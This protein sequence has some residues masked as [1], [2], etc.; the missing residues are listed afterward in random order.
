MN[1]I[2]LTFAL[3]ISLLLIQSTAFAQD[4]KAGDLVGTWLS[5]DGNGHIHIYEASGKYF[6]KS[7]SATDPESD[8]TKMDTNNADEKRKNTLLV[9]VFI[10]KDFEYDEDGEWE[11]GTIYDPADGKTYKCVIEMSDINT[12][13]VTGY[14]GI[15]LFGRTED[16]TRVK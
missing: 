2:K 12:I 10:L 15:T 11:D 16:W 14:V 7:T 9:D 13:E 1:T 5:S 3:F 8:K 6:A 4:F